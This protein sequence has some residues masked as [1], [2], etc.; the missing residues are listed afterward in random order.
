MNY[1]CVFVLKPRYIRRCHISMQY[2]LLYE[3]IINILNLWINFK[4]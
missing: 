3:E 2:F 4:I 1:T